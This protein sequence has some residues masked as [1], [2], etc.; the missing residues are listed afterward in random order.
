MYPL[1][2][3]REKPVGVFLPASFS[4]EFFVC[5]FLA[6]G[7]DPTVLFKIIRTN[8]CVLV[9]NTSGRRVVGADGRT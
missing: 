5:L 2:L 6:T 1:Q 9:L 7:N 4:S 3:L 8:F